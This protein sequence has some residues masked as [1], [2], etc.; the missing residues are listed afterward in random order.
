LQSEL[1]WRIKDAEELLKSRVPEVKV[2]KMI[3][4]LKLVLTNQVTISTDKNKNYIEESVKEVYKTITKLSEGTET[5]LDDLRL[6]V[7]AQEKKINYDLATRDQIKALEMQDS[8]IKQ[9]LQYEMEQMQ[10]F[11]R[12]MNVRVADVVGKMRALEAMKV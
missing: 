6:I 7:R 8:Q 3:D 2:V 11:I 4:E 5:S 10:Q 12:E 9:Q 1:L